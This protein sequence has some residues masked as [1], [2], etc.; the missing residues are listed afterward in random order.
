MTTPNQLTCAEVF[1]RL[2][3]YV[4]RELAPA[5]LREVESH[6]ARCAACADEFAVERDLLM[7]V[8]AKLASIRVP[9]DLR[10]RIEARLR[11]A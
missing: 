2:D 4:D 1:E 7:A 5:D 9:A 3:D 10:A 11:Q 6:L 8:R